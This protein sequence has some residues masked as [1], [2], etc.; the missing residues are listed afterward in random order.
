MAKTH[1]VLTTG[2]DSG[3]RR[4]ARG[5]V[6]LLGLTVGC[7]AAPRAPSTPSTSAPHTCAGAVVRTQAELSEFASCTTISGD[8]TLVGPELTELTPLSRLKRLVGTLEIAENPSLTDLSGLESLQM[9]RTLRLG[10]IE[11]LGSLRS[12]A[13]AS[14]IRNIE[15]RDAPA[16]RS[17]RGLENV[18][19]LDRLVLSNTGLSRVLGLGN[20]TTA[21]AVEITDNRYLIS[22]EPLRQIRA[23]HRLEV[24]GNPL[25]IGC[26]TQFF[27]NLVHSEFARVERNASFTQAQLARRFDPRDSSGPTLALAQND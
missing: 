2:T 4:I 24:T 9:V 6:A 1:N 22:L 5:A 19:R 20:L 8:L 26:P 14:R 11:N 16:L 3:L 12:L 13:Q 18:T 25:L 7:H 17:L 23:L 21:E 27:P 15:I 10:A